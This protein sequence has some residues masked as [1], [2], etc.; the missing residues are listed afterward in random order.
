VGTLV[1]ILGG[2][3]LF[4]L[5]MVLLT[6]GL[7]GLAGGRLRH[8]LTAAVRGP[9]SGALA[10][11]GATAVVQ[12]SSATIITTIGLVSAGLLSFQQ[13]VGVVVGAAVGTTGTTWLVAILGFKVSVGAAA[14]P[15]LFAGAMLRL[16]GRG[17]AAE[18]GRAAAGFGILFIGIATLVQ[19]MAGI[20]SHISPANMPD[21]TIGGTAILV[22]GGIVMTIMTQSSSVA[23]AA[24]IAALHAGAIHIE[25]AAALVVGQNIGTT[26]SSAIAAIGASTPARRT[27]IAHVLFNLL[28]GGIGLALLPVLGVLTARFPGLG[29]PA[30]APLLVAGFHS[31]F[32]FA[33][34]VVVI[35]SVEPFSRAV[36]R[37]VPQRGPELTRHLDRS[38]ASVPA[39]AAEAARRTV[40]EA[41]ALVIDALAARLGAAPRPGGDPLADAEDALRQAGR[42]IGDLPPESRP[43]SEHR[44][45]LATLHAIDHLLSLVDACREDHAGARARFDPALEEAREALIAAIAR[46]RPALASPVRSRDPASAPA[47]V[48]SLEQASR[49]VAD[50]RRHQRAAVLERTAARHI[51]PDDA[52]ERIEAMRWLDRA[53][54]H[55]WRAMYHLLAPPGDDRGP[56]VFADPAA[57]SPEPGA[58]ANPA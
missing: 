28:A 11:A 21:A 4:V 51:N 36:I 40:L 39:V 10:G 33:A 5:G 54:Y 25:Q 7:K 55:V 44:L 1:Q 23:A 30:A 3:G 19:G 24:T 52:L 13:A 15:I 27:A 48:Q 26:S 22:L 9:L 57:A 16:L 34:A 12:S 6:E 58:G 18:G 29:G 31:T 8:L 45:E 53:G 41:A 37:V 14:M 20:A 32:N 47:P 43:A 2:L 50:V 46:L 49:R 38:V 17:R 35:S 56:E 42:F